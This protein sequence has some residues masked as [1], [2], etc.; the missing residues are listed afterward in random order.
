[1][2]HHVANTIQV[3]KQ[4]R[5]QP[6]SLLVLLP[7]TLSLSPKG[8]Y[9]AGFYDTFIFVLLSIFLP[10]HASQN[11]NIYFSWFLNLHTLNYIVC[12]SLC[13]ASFAQHCEKHPC[14]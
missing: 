6:G 7:I 5:A 13:L 8:N 14:C 11:T 9:Y 2:N 12:I 10:K 1:M 4:N 3:K